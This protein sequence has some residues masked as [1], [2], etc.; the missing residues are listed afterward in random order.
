MSV[1]ARNTF[2]VAAGLALAGIAYAGGPMSGSSGNS[3]NT[4]CG[5]SGHGVVIPGATVGTPKVSSGMMGKGQNVMVPGVNI[6]GANVRVSSPNISLGGV[7]YGSSSMAETT[8]NVETFDQY[9]STQFRPTGGFFAESTSI[10]PSAVNALNVEGNEETYTE[11][12][13]E[14]VP[15]TQTTCVP[16]SG[17]AM[18]ARPVQAVCVDDRGTPHPA[19]RLSAEKHVDANFEGEVFRCMAGTSMRVIIGERGDLTRRSTAEGFQQVSGFS[20]AKGEALVHKRGGQLVCRQQI[21]QRNCNERS[22]LRRNGPGV[23][24]I[25][26][27]MPSACVPTTTT[28]MQPVTRQVQRIRPAK[29]GP[30]VFDGGVGQSVF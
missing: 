10:T 30:M 14:Q 9:E 28:V 6:A 17:H 20:C 18:V 1:S 5:S 24:L 16:Q 29:T 12:I 8:L 15:T 26:T 27:R 2:I 13:T 7:A 23:K 25:Q 22:L 19:S 11:T 3:C 21:P 4:G